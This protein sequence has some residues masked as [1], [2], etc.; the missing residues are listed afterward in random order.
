MTVSSGLD[1]ESVLALRTEAMLG[2]NV[3]TYGILGR[4]HLEKADV[5]GVLDFEEVD[6]L[7]DDPQ[8]LCTFPNAL[9]ACPV[10]CLAF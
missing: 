2:A 3:M 8:M 7:G 10:A 6:F 9:Y 5:Y 4:L 1:R